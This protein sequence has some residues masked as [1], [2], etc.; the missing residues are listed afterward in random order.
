M[1][2]GK[3]ITLGWLA[4]ISVAG[5]NFY[6]ITLV[7]SSSTI[8]AY[9]VI[10]LL[11]ALIA[12]TQLAE[13]GLGSALQNYISEQNA[14]QSGSNHTV[15]GIIQAY[16]GLTIIAML[17]LS[18]VGGLIAPIYLGGVYP[19]GSE[20]LTNVFVST[21]SLLIM[22]NLGTL[23]FKIYNANREPWIG[24]LYQILGSV[25]TILLMLSLPRLFPTPDLLT[26]A[27]FYFLGPA[28][29]SLFSFI[30]LLYRYK[31]NIFSLSLIQIERGI[32]NKIAGGS[33]NF[34]VFNVVSAFV[35]TAD[36][37]VMSQLLDAEDIA[38]YGTT[39]KVFGL[40][41]V[42]YSS[43]LV[44]EWPKC[45]EDFHLKKSN[46]H[47][48]VLS[49][50]MRFG[51]AY[52]LVFTL[53]FAVSISK[54][55]EILG[56]GT[57]EVGILFPLLFGGYF[58]IRIFT[59]TYTMLL[60]SMSELKPIILLTPV[61]AFLSFALQIFFVFQFGLNGVL[62]GLIL[63]YLLTVT[64]FLPVFYVRSINR[65]LRN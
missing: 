44:V 18:L 30:G 32:I 23:A 64:S 24:Y 22:V 58:V 43:I 31:Y 3:D 29:A 34:L 48:H 37:V 49:R 20:V 65:M 41:F 10:L 25:L 53:V 42:M 52:T 15:T 56:M 62:I 63:S 8:A 60:Q 2:F 59:D 33:L 16:L 61:Q 13:L 51:I 17:L 50:I 47:Q 55:F 35:L 36:Y 14:K 45:S 19:E 4:R 12:W 39:L 46:R 1:T 28:I 27:I 9:S 6:A 57:T 40:V 11:G 26:T 21:L 7:L 5:A 38:F 54:F